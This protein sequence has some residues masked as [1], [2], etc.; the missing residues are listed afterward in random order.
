[1][2][3]QSALRDKSYL[4]AI[5]IV[6]LARELQSLKEFVL[7]RHVLRSGSAVGALTR[8]AE[9]AQSK[10]DFIHKMSISLKEANE[11]YYWLTSYLILITSLKP[12]L[13]G[14]T[15]R[16]TKANFNS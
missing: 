5:K 14:S 9:F 13:L 7:S 15:I 16:T 12:S 1:M 4:F 3:K 2:K 11:T 10:A 6:E 8:E